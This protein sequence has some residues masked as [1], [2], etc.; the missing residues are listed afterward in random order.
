M[1]I[2]NI[3]SKR[4]KYIWRGYLLIQFIYTAFWK[5]QKYRGGKIMV[6]KDLEWERELDG[7]YTRACRTA[8]LST[9]IK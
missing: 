9:K 5:R 4:K 1:W 2:L 7:E 8:K 3:F 6:F